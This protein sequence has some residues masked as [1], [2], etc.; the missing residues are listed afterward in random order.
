MIP[1]LS[2]RAFRGLRSVDLSGLSRLNLIIGGNNVGKTSILEALVLLYGNYADLKR[3]PGLFRWGCGNGESERDFWSLLARD[4]S[5]DGFVLESEDAKVIAEPDP[6][7][8][9]G[10]S[11]VRT[12]KQAEGSSA[13]ILQLD[14]EGCGELCEPLNKSAQTLSIITADCPIAAVTTRRYQQLLEKHPRRAEELHSL[15]REALEPRASGLRLL[16]DGEDGAAR[17]LAIEMDGGRVLPFSQMGQGFARCF[18]L[19]CEILLGESRIVLIDEV[20]SGLYYRSLEPLWRGVLPL[21]EQLDVQVFATTHSLECMQA[22]ARA[23]SSCSKEAVAFIR[24]DRHIRN[25][26]RINA[27]VFPASTLQSAMDFGEE[28]R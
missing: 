17:V 27:V 25:P 14:A 18:H 28:M 16:P 15:L 8:S 11:L 7:A 13:S 3:L 10:W 20:E 12:S 2:L 4:R 22:A 21:L 9:K 6:S 26:E 5:F 24:L 23:E 1:K 19:L